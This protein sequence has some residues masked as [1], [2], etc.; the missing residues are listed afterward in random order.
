M[1]QEPQALSE[2]KIFARQSTE[3]SGQV[4]EKTNREC[5]LVSQLALT[6]ALF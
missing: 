4:L 5:S 2:V 3:E 1:V 6:L